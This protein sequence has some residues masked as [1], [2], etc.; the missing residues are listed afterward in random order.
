MRRRRTAGTARPVVLAAPSALEQAPDARYDRRQHFR[1]V[2]AR[3]GRR[4]RVSAR[5]VGERPRAADARVAGNCPT[6]SRLLP[7]AASG[8]ASHWLVARFM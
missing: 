2:E 3:A 6:S 5:A 1:H 8:S 7:L 4:G